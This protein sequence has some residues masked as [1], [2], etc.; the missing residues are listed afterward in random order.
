M[1]FLKITFTQYSPEQDS[2][3]KHYEYLGLE[4]MDT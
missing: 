3:G 1:Y 2:L 4:D